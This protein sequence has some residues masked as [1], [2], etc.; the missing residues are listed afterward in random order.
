MKFNL[1][2]LSQLLQDSGKVWNRFPFV[3]SIATALS[4]VV[5][6]LNHDVFG[7]QEDK[8]IVRI[9]FASITLIPLGIGI[10]IRQEVQSPSLLSTVILYFL[11]LGLFYYLF[12]LIDADMGEA[13]LLQYFL[14]IA[15]VHLL[16]CSLPFFGTN[17]S[18]GFWHYNRILL[19]RILLSAFY[20]GFLYAGLT[21]ALL[22]LQFL[23]GINVRENLYGDTGILL[24]G[25]FNTWFFLAGIPQNWTELNEDTQYPKGLR[26]FSEY[27]LIP[28]VIVYLIILYLY[29]GKTMIKQE[30]PLTW[31]GYLVMGFS[32][33]GILAM[34]LVWPIRQIKENAWIHTFSKWY[35]SALIPLSILLL[36]T[37]G[38]QI[39]QYGITPNRYVLAMLTVWVLAISIGYSITGFKKILYIPLSLTLVCLFAGIGGPFNLLSVS[40]SNQQHRMEELLNQNK[41]IQ[42]GKFCTPPKEISAEDLREISNKLEFLERN[43][44]ST[45]IGQYMNSSQVDSL[46]K[47]GYSAQQ[48]YIFTTV[49]MNTIG[50]YSENEYSRNYENAQLNNYSIQSGEKGI[51]VVGY[52]SIQD[53]S[54]SNYD[55]T[56]PDEQS[57]D[58]KE[59]PVKL[60]HLEKRNAFQLEDPDGSRT[61]IALSDSLKSWTLKWGNPNAN[62]S[63]EEIRI[64]SSTT[65]YLVSLVV[66]DL[67]IAKDRVKGLRLERIEGKIMIQEKEK[68]IGEIK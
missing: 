24:G 12:Q 48:A 22:A 33:S 19:T 51:S 17:K 5:L 53:F 10:R 60:Y 15:A 62:T 25:I 43:A 2:S 54:F 21:L 3:L 56:D 39:H 30:W 63:A 44:D 68:N 47:E 7:K 37:I 27:V 46:Y 11:S 1:P 49:L 31:M 41:A 26:I 61:E 18:L 9:L 35:L 58:L 34:L 67:S 52:T 57:V 59:F 45:W 64:K 40:I 4:I 23:L 50:G 66:T 8:T 36:I 16:A 42:E 20:T 55:E 38:R 29:A 6:L 14:S 32:V 28:L 65:H 13:K